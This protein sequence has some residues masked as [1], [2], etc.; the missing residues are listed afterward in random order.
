MD[1]PSAGI[2]IACA[3]YSAV[4]GKI[5]D[6]HTAMTGELSINGDV[7]PV[8]GIKAKVG[9]AQKAGAKRVIIPRENQKEALKVIGIE[10]VCV[11]SVAEVFDLVFGG[12][13]KPLVLSDIKAQPVVLSAH[14][15]T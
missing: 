2:S 3:V 6:C 11:S 13:S 8:G 5:P 1:G 9:A 10:V 12:V 15:I 4:T 14:V 7:M